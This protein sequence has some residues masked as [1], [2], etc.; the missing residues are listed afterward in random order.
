MQKSR[1]LYDPQQDRSLV[2][3]T[4]HDHEVGCVTCEA[5]A[6][7]FLGYPDRAITRIYDAL[8]RARDL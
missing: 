7:W 1:L 4:G 8:T 3:R 6:L 2:L 5:R